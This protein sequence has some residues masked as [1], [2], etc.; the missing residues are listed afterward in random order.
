MSYGQ[1]FELPVIELEE[2]MY[3]E[4]DEYTVELSKEYLQPMLSSYLD[5]E[6]EYVDEIYEDDNLLLIFEI[7]MNHKNSYAVTS[8]TKIWFATLHEIIN[9]NKF[10]N[11]SFS[12]STISQ[13]K[14]CLNYYSEFKTPIIKYDGSHSKKIMFESTFGVSKRDEGDGQGNIFRFY[15]FFQAYDKAKETNKSSAILRYVVFSK[16]EITYDDFLPLTLH[17]LPL[18]TENYLL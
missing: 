18:H 1:P 15:D 13:V 4:K 14:A 5:V 9:E 10:C 2:K 16:D 6:I 7:N 12:E 17:P 3:Y 11:I 8:A